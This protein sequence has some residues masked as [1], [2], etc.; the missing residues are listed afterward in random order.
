M[1]YDDATDLLHVGTSY[2]RSAFK[3]LVRVESEA[4][5]VGTPTAISAKG[6]VIVMGGTNAKVYQPALQLR[7]EL[8][9]KEEA[10]R[11]LGKTPVFFDFDATTGQ[12]AFTLQQ[13]Y[14]AKAIYSAGTL[15]RLGSTKDYTVSN[16]GYRE[17]INFNVA[18]GNAVWVSIMAV[19][20]N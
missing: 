14:T 3:G 18:P 11:A 20:S 15:K 2:G 19:R 1:D 9:R 17:T 4:T 6:G 10:R 5:T 7:D 16:D 13:G 12:T 8:A